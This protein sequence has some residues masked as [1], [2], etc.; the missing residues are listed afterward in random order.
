MITIAI[1]TY[2]RY[3]ILRKM[4][5]SLYKSN[6]NFPYSIRIYDDC[7]KEF[8][9]I[10]L[11]ELFPNAVSIHI[12]EV[13]LRSDKNIFS[14][15]NDFLSTS[16]KYLFNAD[17]DL[18]FNIDWLSKGL[19]LIEKTDGILTIFNAS[20][21]PVINNYDDT[22]CIKK[23]IGS[24]GTFFTR[25]RIEEIINYCKNNNIKGDYSLDWKWSEYFFNNNVRIFCT[26]KSLVQHIGFT[27][28]NSNYFY[29]YGK[30]FKVD[31]I[32]QGQVIND[33]FEQ[34]IDN[35][36]NLESI[37]KKDFKY[38]FK[39]CIIIVMRKILPKKLFEKIKEKYHR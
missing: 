38:N 24:A 16:D 32:E 31:T 29:D 35:V 1:P 12:N 20:S 33:I 30:N 4:S 3:N 5:E 34:Y 22:F 18:I 26:N 37:H 36:C 27:G 23:H 11:K 6:L 13:N 2:N 28:Q 8:G 10:E 9:L 15:Y 7:S 14:I 17:S 39:R 25:S 21:H 19:E